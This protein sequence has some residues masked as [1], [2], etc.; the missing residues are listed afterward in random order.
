MVGLDIIF[1]KQI[2][3]FELITIIWILNSFN[4]I[5]KILKVRRETRVIFQNREKTSQTRNITNSTQCL[6]T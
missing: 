6:K 2:G 4:N 1:M 5:Q 3:Y